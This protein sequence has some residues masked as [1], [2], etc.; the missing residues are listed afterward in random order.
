MNSCFV[1]LVHLL[2]WGMAA[3]CLNYLVATPV[4]FTQSLLIWS[5]YLMWT[6]AVLLMV[7]A[8]VHEWQA[9]ARSLSR[10]GA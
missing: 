9:A 2:W 8:S 1:R 4:T 6:L 10:K 3:K 7:I 5:C